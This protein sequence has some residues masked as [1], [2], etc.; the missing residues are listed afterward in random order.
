MAQPE[1]R[2]EKRR[3][4][5]VAKQLQQMRGRPRYAEYGACIFAET[6]MHTAGET[7]RKNSMKLFGKIILPFFDAVCKR[8][9]STVSDTLRQPEM[10][11]MVK[12]G[13]APSPPLPAS[14]ALIR[15]F[16]QS[17]GPPAP[18]CQRRRRKAPY[19]RRAFQAAS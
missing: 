15:V 12:A 18:S 13:A 14:G 6:K 17:A 1:L 5:A 11:G 4:S 9:S 8:K 7:L 3:G 16:L 10:A 19:E 2:H